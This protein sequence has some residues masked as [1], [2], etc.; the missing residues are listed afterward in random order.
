MAGEQIQSS[1]SLGLK[2]SSYSSVEFL[3]FLLS[4]HACDS[5]FFVA[6]MSATLRLQFLVFVVVPLSHSILF[7]WKRAKRT[8]PRPPQTQGFPTNS[9]EMHII[10]LEGGFG[11]PVCSRRTVCHIHIHKMIFAMEHGRQDFPSSFRGSAVQE[12]GDHIPPKRSPL[13]GCSVQYAD[14]L[15]R[16]KCDGRNGCRHSHFFRRCHQFWGD[17]VPKFGVPNSDFCARSGC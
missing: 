4:V 14:D 7:A 2:S 8:F 6:R 10:I 5:Q 9:Y 1:A 13:R 11:T 3:P 16:M 15:P 17:V 12:S